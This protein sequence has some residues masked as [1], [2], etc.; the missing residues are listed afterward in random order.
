ME[1]WKSITDYE[2]LYEVSNFGR[3]RSLPRT[4]AF[5]NQKR[6]T[7]YMIIA[8]YIRPAGYATVKLGKDGKKRNAYVHRLVALA[9]L[10]D[11][12]SNHEVCHRDGNKTNNTSSNLY[13]GT[14]KQNIADNIRLGRHPLGEA[15]GMSKVT[16][17]DVFAIRSDPRSPKEIAMD[18]PISP[19]SISN[20]K[21]R[22][23]WKHI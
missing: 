8:P 22:A 6:T 10:G 23:N 19:A 15:H 4:V 17:A 5:G 1:I 2:E 9:F 3:V 18:Y 14:R 16:E 12:P 20:I 7:P 21:R 11:C 13:W